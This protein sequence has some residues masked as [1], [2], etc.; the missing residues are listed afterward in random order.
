MTYR[1]G[2]HSTSDDSSAYRNRRDVEDWKRLDNPL[3]RFG[4]YCQERG[5]WS[6]EEGEVLRKQ[7]RKDIVKQLEVAEHKPRPSISSLFQDTYKEVPANL[8]EQRSELARLIQMYGESEA[9]KKELPKY[10]HQGKDM[11]PFRPKDV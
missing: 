9:W 2:H 7:Y 10:R 5:W 3:A 4:A 11:E 1:V 6:E 8:Q